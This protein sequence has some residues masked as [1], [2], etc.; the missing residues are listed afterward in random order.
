MASWA[1]V[2]VWIMVMCEGTSSWN[3]FAS[4][5]LTISASL[6]ERR[7]GPTLGGVPILFAGT[8]SASNLRFGFTL[9]CGEG[10]YVPLGTL[11]DVKGGTGG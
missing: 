8:E 4:S 7:G 2:L 3:V 5:C 1:T 9:G 6:A 11:I 10:L